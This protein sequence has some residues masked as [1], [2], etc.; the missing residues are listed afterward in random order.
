VS[1]LLLVVRRNLTVYFRD[2]M[3]VFFALLS[4]LILIGLYALFLGQLQVDAL[5]ARFPQATEQEVRGFVFSWVFSGIVMITSLTT[6]LSA[7]SAFV[8]DRAS[9][10]FSDFLVSPVRRGTLVLGYLLSSFAV[11]V[12]IT[13]VVLVVGELFLLT[14][15][16][17]LMT[18]GQLAACVGWILL[19]AAAF[20]ALS[21]FAVSFLRSSGAF[22]ALSTI[23]GTVVGFLAGAYIP[24]GTLPDAAVRIISAL[25]FAQSAMLIRE[26]FCAE[27]LDALTS[28]QQALDAVRDFYGVRLTV[29]DLTITDPLA[30]GE[31]ALVLILFTALAVWRLRRGIR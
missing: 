1:A 13:L 20:A 16:L 12:L 11:S 9:G 31:L 24:P 6:S 15:G 18:I 17:P 25:P 22:A 7:I 23:V 19:S 30:A 8:D 27:P 3:G 21:S 28:N 26:Q 4:A 29:G 10:R 2:R 5:T 14:Q